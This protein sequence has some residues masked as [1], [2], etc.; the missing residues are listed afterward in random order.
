MKYRIFIDFFF[1]FFFAV[2]RYRC[3]CL[4][5]DC[6]HSGTLH[7]DLPSH[8]IQIDLHFKS[9]EKNYWILLVICYF[10]LYTMVLPNKTF[11]RLL[12]RR[13]S[14][15]IFE[16]EWCSQIYN[17][18]WRQTSMKS[19]G[20]EWEFETYLVKSRD[21]FSTTRLRDQKNNGCTCTR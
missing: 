8:Q 5:F 12:S 18:H 2:F 1:F 4:V 17:V 6:I 9:C 10:V 13:K 14:R 15:R 19:G 11:I 7:C 16:C 20:A 3:I 21:L